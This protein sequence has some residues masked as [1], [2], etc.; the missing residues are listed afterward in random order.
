M[1]KIQWYLFLQN[2]KEIKKP[3][4]RDCYNAPM[5][6][7]LNIA[8]I[9]G[10]DKRL[11]HLYGSYIS[12]D[13]RFQTDILPDIDHCMARLAQKEFLAAVTVSQPEDEMIL[14]DLIPLISVRPEKFNRERSDDDQY[15]QGVTVLTR[16]FDPPALLRMIYKAVKIK[17]VDSAFYSP[18]KTTPTQS[19]TQ[20][21]NQPTFIGEAP[22][23]IAIKKALRHV[24]P[25]GAPVMIRG[26]SGT[27]KEVCAQSLHTLSARAKHPFIAI[28]CGAIPDN[29][30]ESELFGHVK[31]AFTG[32][33][34]D[35][36]GA[37]KKAAGGTLFLDE[38]ADLSLNAQVK[39]LRFLQDGTYRAVGETTTMTA[40]LRIVSATNKDIEALILSGH[41][42]EDL[43]FRLNVVPFT[44]PTLKARGDD[45]IAL[46]LFFLERYAI[47][48]GRDPPQLDRDARTLLKRH[49]WPGNVRELQN[50]LRRAVV[51]SR[52]DRLSAAD[53]SPFLSAVEPADN[54]GGQ[55]WQPRSLKVIEREAITQTL[56]YCNGKVPDAAALLE[57]NPSTVYRKLECYKK[58]ENH[59]G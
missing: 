24:A 54:N 12:R 18:D 48:E 46:A 14:A 42:R 41:F 55:L 25:S 51:M 53:L 49:P 47:E 2:A 9:A 50:T 32:A 43:Y 37:I 33:V 20:P 44:L 39:L 38:V 1:A 8:V 26:P 16:P 17:P 19:Q 27:G 57:I 13:K 30:F 7:H 58:E 4:S 11:A 36:D 28:N 5:N 6:S 52:S 10:D 40:D 59:T 45:I 29:L 23:I 21:P 15:A 34:R 56:R 31:G 35:R 22:E 3:A